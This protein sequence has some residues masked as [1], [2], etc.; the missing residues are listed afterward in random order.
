MLAERTTWDAKQ[1]VY[2]QM[3]HDGLPRLNKP[4]EGCADGHVAVI[5]KHIRKKKPFCMGQIMAGDKVALFTSLKADVTQAV[6]DAAGDYYDFDTQNNSKLFDRMETVF[7]HMLLKGR[8]ILRC[9]I[10]PM[11]DYALVD[12]AIDP[13]FIIMPWEANDFE[14]ADQFVYVRSFSVDSYKR[15]PESQWNID[16]QTINQIRGSKSLSQQINTADTQKYQREGLTFTRHENTIL[17]YEHY[18]KTKSGWT[19]HYY[20]PQN[21]DL[22]IRESH[23]LPFTCNGK[24]SLDF[25]SFSYENKDEGWYSPRGLGELLAPWEQWETK[26]L[27]EKADALTFFNR[28]I[29]TVNSREMPNVSNIRFRPGEV[30][31]DNLHSVQ[32]GAPPMSFDDERMASR[33]EAEEIAQ[34]PDF[35][36]A[37]EGP[38]GG[39]GRTA[40]ENNRIAALQGAGN[41]YDGNRWRRVMSR[42]HK[43]RWALIAEYRKK[44]LTY[45]ISGEAKVLPQQA[46]HD[47]YIIIPDGSP[48]GWNPLLRFQKAASLLQTVAGNPNVDQSVVTENLLKAFDAR[49]AQRAF[50]PNNQ[51]G[52][53]DYFDE[54]IKIAS[55]I[56]VPQGHP[57]MQPPIKPQENQAARIQAIVQWIQAAEMQRTPFNDATK[58]LLMQRVAQRFQ[59]LQQQ[60]PDAAKQVMQMVQQVE[61]QSQAMAQQ[62]AP[63]PQQSQEVLA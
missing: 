60:N 32:Q 33:M 9:G 63:Q 22:Q 24:P 47:S 61:Q 13:V 62:Q 3:R 59:I 49:I 23:A 6:A 37:Q 48:D 14:D 56:A 36:I 4:F 1:R 28:P 27:N 50:I 35:G 29:Y 44:E 15:L 42:V 5:D 55:L 20:S 38:T 43:H 11:R 31:P 12:T 54:C 17:I 41:N 53:D 57:Q 16:Q 21:P 10:D 39:K 51:Q 30:V 25:F 58:R 52:Q 45:F 34:S 18:E 7:D 26:V 46:L 2:Y 8:G 40:T 19:I